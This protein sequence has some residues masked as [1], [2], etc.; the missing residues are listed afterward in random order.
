MKQARGAAAGCDRFFAL[1]LPLGLISVVSAAPAIASGCS[2]E[3]QGEGRVA[4]IIDAR[5]FR[6]EDGREVRLAGIEPIAAEQAGST[7]TLSAILKG[8]GVTLRGEDDTPDRYGRQAAFVFLDDSESSVQE[9]G[10][11]RGA[12]CGN[13]HRQGLRQKPRRRGG[14]G[15]KCEKGN[16]G[17]FRGH[18]KRGK[19]GRYFG[20]DRALYGGRRQGF[21]GPAGRGDDLPEFRTKLDTGL[22]CDY[23]K[24]HDPGI[25]GSWNR[26]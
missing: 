25:R 24:A 6:L 1:V 10:R 3:A 11:R 5:G 26:T 23:F 4:A 2:F 9:I 13:R 22:C 15:A 20:R 17:R 16:L 8:H 19:S 12:G 18:K 14:G 7:S 21:I